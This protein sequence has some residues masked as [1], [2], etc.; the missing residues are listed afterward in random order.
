MKEVIKVE[1]LKKSF[2][3]NLVLDDINLSFYDKEFVAISGESGSGKTTLLSIISTLDLPTSGKVFYNGKSIYEVDEKELTKIRKNDIGI[4]FQRFYLES[5]YSV[6]ENVTLP[7]QFDKLKKEEK[8]RRGIEVLK[9]CNID[10]KKDEIVSNLS[11]GEM[12]RVAI[13]RAIINNPKIIFADEPCG[14]LDSKNGY[15]IMDLLKKLNDEGRLIILVTHN[16]EHT[17]YAS[18][19]I[20]LVDGKIIEDKNNV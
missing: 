16:K 2:G 13:A 5:H 18:R 17:K 19:I 7:L 8:I 11:G 14:N 3:S 20:K 10:N 1:N 4:V 15:I 9:L 6:L 12:Q